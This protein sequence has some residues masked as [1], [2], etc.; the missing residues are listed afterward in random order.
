M[1]VQ[2]DVD[3]LVLGA[4]PAAAAAG[5]HLRRA[6]AD[7]ALVDRARTT[8]R[9][10]REVVTAPT[11][12][13]LRALG[14]ATAPEGALPCRGLLALWDGSEQFH[15]YALV[16]CESAHALEPRALQQR[17]LASAEAMGI[18]TH[19]AGALKTR[20][21]DGAW[22]VDLRSAGGHRRIR[23]RSL[24]L[25]AGRSCASLLVQG[26][27]RCH[28]D[29]Q[30]ALTLIVR[31]S[32]AHDDVLVVEAAPSGWW[33][34]APSKGREGE[35][36]LLTD[37]DLLPREAAARRAFVLAQ[38]AAT[39]FIEPSLEDV[40]AGARFTGCDARFSLATP[41]PAPRCYAIGDAVLALD[42]LSG[43]GLAFAL[44]SARVAAA[45]VGTDDHDA[46]ADWVHARFQGEASDR[47]RSYSRAR[48]SRDSTYWVRRR[49]ERA[50][51]T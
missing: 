15:D 44:E 5:I 47:L 27:G 30:V 11:L 23:S 24:F 20:W 21:A 34:A 38:L 14:V 37:S 7:V 8:A 9:R 41:C 13:A 1:P 36:V 28:F 42:P 4:G 10:P 45:C 40:P 2:E 18:R 19:L 25:A 26:Q 29:R 51:G 35:I 31:R 39:R 48:P 49:Q 6:G 17:L 46:Y 12:R 16:Q 3:V 33:Y 32:G 43:R 22:E 50:G